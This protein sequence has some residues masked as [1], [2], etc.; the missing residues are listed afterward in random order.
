MNLNRV[1]RAQ[2]IIGLIG[3][4]PV[5][6]QQMQRNYPNKLDIREW[7]FR[8]VVRSNL[9]KIHHIRGVFRGGGYWEHVLPSPLRPRNTKK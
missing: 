1:Q 7:K 4:R 5:E 8:Q 3:C 2:L 9:I 6:I